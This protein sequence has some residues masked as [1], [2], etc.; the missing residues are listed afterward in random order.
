MFFAAIDTYSPVSRWITGSTI[1]RALITVTA[2]PAHW[3][4]ERAASPHPLKLMPT[5][6][7]ETTCRRRNAVQT[8]PAT[9]GC[10]G[11][12]AGI[13][14]TP[15]PAYPIAIPFP[16]YRKSPTASMNAR[17]AAT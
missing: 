12:R 17:T 1:P 11:S 2:M 5:A 6:N 10:S 3:C 9:S 16:R 15:C 13:Q 14:T 8:K 4:D 7:R